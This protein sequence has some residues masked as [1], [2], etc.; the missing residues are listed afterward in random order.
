MEG[1]RRSGMQSPGQGVGDRELDMTFTGDDISYALCMLKRLTITV[2]SSMLDLSSGVA[3]RPSFDRW[4]L[5]VK[6]TGWGHEAG[7]F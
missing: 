3:D 7:G 5:S 4:R 6:S 1:T 2:S